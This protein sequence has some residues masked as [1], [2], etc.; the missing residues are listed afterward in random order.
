MTAADLA[1]IRLIKDWLVRHPRAC[2]PIP[3]PLPSRVLIGVWATRHPK[4]AHPWRRP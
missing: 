1:Q 3:T 4:R 2:R